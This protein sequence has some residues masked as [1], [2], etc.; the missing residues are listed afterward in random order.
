MNSNEKESYGF[1]LIT[2]QTSHPLLLVLIPFLAISS[3][4]GWVYRYFNIIDFDLSFF[5]GSGGEYSFQIMDGVIFVSIA[6][7][8]SVIIVFTLKYGLERF[9]KLFFSIGL[10]LSPVSM[11]WL[12]GY[13]I[14]YYLHNGTYWFEIIFA[15]IGVII[16]VF[17]IWA[18]VF[19]KGNKHLRN[20]LV[21]FL[22]ITLGSIFGLLLSLTTYLTLIILISLFDIYSVFKG[23]INKMMQKTNLHYGPISPLQKKETALGIGDFIFYS[24]LVAFATSNFGLAIGFASIVGLL[25]GVVLTEKLLMKFGR[26]PGL[27]LPIFLSLAFLGLGYLISTFLSKSLY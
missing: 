18:F 19:K 20:G 26:F 27:P 6:A 8:S 5:F 25:L 1:L 12:H 13:L 9:L 21:I 23:P 16:G 10:F 11:L 22:G 7:L 3:L 14:D 24:S 17:V 2:Y 15:I 4:I